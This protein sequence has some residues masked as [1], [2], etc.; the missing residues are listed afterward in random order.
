VRDRPPAGPGWLHEIKFDGYRVIARKDGERVRLWAR[1]TPDYSSTF[2]RIPKTSIPAS[3]AIE[4]IEVDAR[5][6]W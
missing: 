4:I 2:T 3:E 6:E 5:N 1:T